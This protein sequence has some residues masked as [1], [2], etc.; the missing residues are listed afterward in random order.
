M[1]YTKRRGDIT[2]TK[3]ERIWKLLFGL[4]LLITAGVMY[5]MMKYPSTGRDAFFLAV[6]TVAYIAL[7]GYKGTKMKKK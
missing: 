2:M 4:L 6:L 3:Q 5:L 1:L 7:G